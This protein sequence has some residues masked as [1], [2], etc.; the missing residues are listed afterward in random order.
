MACRII[1]SLVRQGVTVGAYKPVASGAPT[2]EQSD[3]FLLW[4]ASGHRGTLDQVN[5]QRFLAP[6]APPLSAEKEGKQVSELLIMDGARD[7]G[8]RCEL[9]VLE[10]AGG[11]MSPISWG[12]T[13]ADLAREMKFPIALVSE[14][15]LGVVNQVLTTLTAARSLGLH[16]CCVILNDLRPSE[17]DMQE[18]NERLLRCFLEREPQSPLIVRVARG[19]F[20]FSPQVDWRNL[21]LGTH[22]PTN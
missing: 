3:G 8:H 19:S 13:N 7:W 12:M 1:E 14:N 5:P 6:L 10:G 11:L 20:E 18:S 16:V 22:R 21:C 15:R 9:L 17:E 2:V 4:K